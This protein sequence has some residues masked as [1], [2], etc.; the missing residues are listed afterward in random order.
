MKI[1]TNLNNIEIEIKAKGLYNTE[2][3]NKAD[4]LAFLNNLSIIAADAAKLYTQCG[5]PDAL[6][7][8]AEQFADLLYKICKENGAYNE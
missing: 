3:N 5:E 4:L 8:E 1:K 6:A 7:N 2:R